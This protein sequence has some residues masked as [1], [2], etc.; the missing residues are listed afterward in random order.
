[1]PVEK[2]SRIRLNIH[3][4]D[5]VSGVISQEN[6]E[7]RY[8]LSAPLCR[9]NVKLKCEGGVIH[10]G[11]VRPGLLRLLS[12]GERV[13]ITRR[14]RLAALT[15]SF[16]GAEFRATVAT[17]YYKRR[18]IGLGLVNPILK[19]NCHVESLCRML[20][21]S[22]EIE[23]GQ[24]QLFIDGLSHSLLALLLDAHGL[25]RAVNSYTKGGLTDAQLANCMDYAEA[26][27]GH[28]LDLTAWAGVLGMSANE[29]ARRFQQKTRVAPYAWFMTRRIDRAKEMLLRT[30]LPTVEVALEVGFCSQSHFTE[31]FR[32]RVGRSPARWRAM[33][34]A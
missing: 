20:S 25:G 21:S 10:D 27:L 9:G 7:D 16:P 6:S 23:D 17:D 3:S 15:V 1:M 28:K 2:S 19:P 30:D 11:D 29:F 13:Q 32:R 18:S 4:E 22:N 26:S 34:Q 14:S 31:A 12:P 8:V 5:T 24:R 33:H